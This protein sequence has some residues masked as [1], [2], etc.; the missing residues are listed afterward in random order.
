VS[1]PEETAALFRALSHPARV[2]LLRLTW[3][4][5]RSGE[6]LCGLLNLSAA[7]ISH[8]LSQLDAAGLITAEQ[9]GHHRLHRAHRAA[10]SPTLAE[11]VQART[12]SPRQPAGPFPAGPLTV[13]SEDE[14]FRAKVLATFLKGGRLSTIPAQRKKR[15]VIL[16]WLAAEFEAGREYPERE[17]NALLGTYHPDFF[18]LRREL[19]GR[20]LLTREKGI[21]RRAEAAQASSTPG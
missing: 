10:F 9:Q 18:T 2:L 8:H 11:L 13:Q 12:D 21:Y 14:R 1:S 3:T 6:E 20:G 16:D 19:V 7:T 15:D 17:V 5:P 4:Q